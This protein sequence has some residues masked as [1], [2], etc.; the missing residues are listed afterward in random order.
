M[1]LIQVGLEPTFNLGGSV[2]HLN[3]VRL[4]LESDLD[5]EAKYFYICLLEFNGTTTPYRHFKLCSKNSYYL[6]DVNIT[7]LVNGGL[8]SYD[9]KK[10][11]KAV[12]HLYTI[13]DPKKWLI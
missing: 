12:K 1:E 7:T 2:G 13:K 9:A 11:Y 6:E 3:L 5:I 4:I 8:I 10:K